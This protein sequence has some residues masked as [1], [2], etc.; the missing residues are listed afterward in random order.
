MSILGQ[1]LFKIFVRNVDNGIE[2]TLS[3]FVDDTMLS[4]VVDTREGRDAIQRDLDKLERNS[5]A[6]LEVMEEKEMANLQA[7]E[8]LP[9]AVFVEVQCQENHGRQ[10]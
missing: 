10:S 3:K 7:D 9:H 6:L 8:E 2:C 5:G 4:G 1:V